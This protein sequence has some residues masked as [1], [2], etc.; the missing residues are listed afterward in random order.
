MASCCHRPSRC[1]PAIDPGHERPQPGCWSA[2]LPGRCVSMQGRGGSTASPRGAGLWLQAQKRT[3]LV[4]WR[5][6]GA[7]AHLWLC[8]HGG[9]R[10]TR[11]PRGLR[12]RKRWLQA[13]LS[14][15]PRRGEG[16]RSPGAQ[17]F[18][19]LPEG[20]STGNHKL[21]PEPWPPA[22]GGRG[23]VPCS[24]QGVPLPQP[25]PGVPG[26]HGRAEFPR[27]RAPAQRASPAARRAPAA[28]RSLRPMVP[29]PAH[30]PALPR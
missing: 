18:V 19:C 3:D 17:T 15:S 14:P 9:A 23:S 20:S 12:E 24:V 2:V 4:P 30:G 21:Q 16:V 27:A 22:H 10:L 5:L 6:L 13:G 8:A 7:G 11:L 28:Q 26:A 25:G 1:P 29:E